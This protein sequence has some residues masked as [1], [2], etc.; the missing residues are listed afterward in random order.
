MRTFTKEEM[1]QADACDLEK[2]RDFYPWMLSTRLD[3][4]PD[5]RMLESDPQYE[6]LK[7]AKEKYGGI[8]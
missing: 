2:V 7:R 8:S 3:R 6:I 4:S 5:G 1:A